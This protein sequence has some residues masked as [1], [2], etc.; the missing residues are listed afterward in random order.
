MRR[1]LTLISAVLLAA[2]LTAQPVAAQDDLPPRPEAASNIVGGEQATTGQF[3]W[4]A[5]LVRRGDRRKEGFGCGATVLSRSWILTAGHCVLD[6]DGEYPDSIYGN[7]VAPSYFDVVTGINSL[8]EDGGGQRLQV[9]A[10]NPHP[11]YNWATNDYDVALLRV[12]RPTSAPEIAVIGTSGSELALDD[13]GATA[14]AIGWGATFSGATS[15]PTLQRFVA[16]PVQTSATCSGAYPPGF[17]DPGGFLLEYDASNMICAGPMSGGKDSCQGDSGGPLAVQA[18]DG[19]WRQIGIVSFGLYC[20]EP[21]YPGVYHRLT[22]SA[23]WVAGTTRY[24][25]FNGDGFAFVNRQYQDFV[26]RKPTTSEYASWLNRL[27]SSQPA[28]MIASLA[29]A[30]P[31][32]GNASMNVRLY[33]AAFLRDPDTGGLDYWVQRRWAGRGPVSIAN[34]FTASSEFI[35]KYGSLSNDDFVTRIY[36][37]VFDRNPDPGGRT[38][39]NNKLGRGIGR[40]QMLYELSNSSEYRRDTSTRV[41]IITT[42]FAILRQVPTSNEIATSQAMTQTELINS[43]R[44][45]Y[46]YA[47]RFSG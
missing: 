42:R 14:T 43:L 31:W 8:A 16:L 27:T 24:G 9:T 37:N 39:W 45:S 21:G 4:T 20:A 15:I 32:D 34:H 2:A 38:Y 22:S 13:A 5:A 11:G 10:I 35:N 29:A 26:G 47:S 12:S 6:Y 23:G 46:R 30:A 44:L 33:R 7:Y 40:G 18:G 25:P 3:P 19:S 17:T 1:N 36:Q 28:S 41:R